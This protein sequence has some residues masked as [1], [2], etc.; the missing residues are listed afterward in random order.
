MSAKMLCGLF[1]AFAVGC[2]PS[3]RVEGTVT[4]DGRPV[5]DG[6]IS[7]APADGTG[8][9]FGAALTEGRFQVAAASPVTAGPKRVRI[10]GS[11]K[12]GKRIP[13]GAPPPPDKM[14]GEVRYYPAPGP[15]E[16]ALEA[17]LTAGKV[18][19]LSFALKSGKAEK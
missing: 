12:T 2:G 18:N 11:M 13:A 14:T 16:E 5:N 9:S 4:L 6:S 1:V 15:T 7:F 17:T 8:P 3:T 10:R 19:E